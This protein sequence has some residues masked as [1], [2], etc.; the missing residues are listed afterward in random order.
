MYSIFPRSQRAWISKESRDEI[1]ESRKSADLKVRVKSEI[2]VMIGD[3]SGEVADR[4]NKLKNSCR[5]LSKNLSKQSDLLA[6]LNEWM[7]NV[8]IRSTQ[9]AEKDGEA[10]DITIR[11]REMADTGNVKMNTRSRICSTMQTPRS[12]R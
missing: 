7:S 8:D 1:L 3:S 2:L 11:A 12:R 6:Q 10:S 4:A 9:N 5:Y